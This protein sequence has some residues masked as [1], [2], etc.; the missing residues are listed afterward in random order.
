MLVLEF[1]FSKSTSM[2]QQK[3]KNAKKTTCQT[4]AFFADTNQQMYPKKLST[5]NRLFTAMTPSFCS[6]TDTKQSLQYTIKTHLSGPPM[7]IFEVYMNYI[8]PSP[9][10]SMKQ[11]YK[12]NTAKFHM[13]L[14]LILRPGSNLAAKVIISWLSKFEAYMNN[15]PLS[16]SSSMKQCNKNA[17]VKF[18]YGTTFDTTTRKQSRSGATTLSTKAIIW[19]SMTRL[20]HYSRRINKSILFTNRKLP[21]IHSESIQKSR[22]KANTYSYVFTIGPIP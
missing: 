12:S 3:K 1:I 16:P 19:L 9:P 17:T 10:S 22:S 7:P 8:P 20:H 2:V 5:Q 6:L 18:P 11:Y 13:E 21:S 14:L 15:I 4:I